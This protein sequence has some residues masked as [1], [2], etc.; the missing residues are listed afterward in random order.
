MHRT[1]HIGRTVALLVVAM[2][3]AACQTLGTSQFITSSVTTELSQ[4]AATGIAGD[5]VGRLAEHVGPGTNSIQLRTD[6]TPFGEAIE[7]SL[8]SWGYAVTTDQKAEGANAIP[9]AYVI[10]HFEG[11]VLARLSTPSLDLTR[12]Y[13]LGAAGATPSS[14]LSIMQ[15]SSEIR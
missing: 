9:L 12:M 7:A 13:Q 4:E 10:D 6:G 15:R 14:P 3:L 8:R 1:L 11:S 2:S 5:M